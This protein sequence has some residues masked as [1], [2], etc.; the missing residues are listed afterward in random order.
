MLKLLV[1]QNLCKFNK[2]SSKFQVLSKSAH[3]ISEEIFK[4]LSFNSLSPTLSFNSPSLDWIVKILK[5][6]NGF[7]IGKKNNTKKLSK[8]KKVDWL[9]VLQYDN[10]E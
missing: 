3:R 5:V 10:N 4:T 8:R 7:L 9:T 1:N 6:L 2:V